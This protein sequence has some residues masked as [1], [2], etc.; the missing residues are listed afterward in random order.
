M[1]GEMRSL[2]GWW[3]RGA[4]VALCFLIGGAAQASAQID[5]AG[6]WAALS[7]QEDEVHRI[8]GPEL[9]DYAGFP[10]SEAG[11]VKAETWDASI[12]SQPELQ[13]RPHPAQY[14]MRG[15]FPNFRM[16]VVT[17][18]QTNALVALTITNLFGNADR[19][20]WMD[21]RAHPSPY[22]EHTWDGFSTGTWEGDALRVTTTH[23]KMGYIHRNG[24][25]ASPRST[26]T[27]LF[28]RHDRYLMLVTII[29]DPV[30]LEEPF[31]RTSN[32][33]WA[34][35]QTIPPP[36]PFEVVEELTNL[37]DGSV[38][39][40][41]LET[42][43]TE[44]A[45]RFNLPPAA[46]R[47]GADTMYPEYAKRMQRPSP[48]VSPLEQRIAAPRAVT[49]G[50]PIRPDV[51][52]LQVQGNVYMLVA[53]T[54]NVTAQVGD[55]GIVLVDTGD[56]QMADRIQAELRKLSSKPVRY[57]LNT[58]AGADHVGGNAPIAEAGLNLAAV[59]TAGNSGIPIVAA[60]IIAHENVLSRMSAP[61]GS[62]SPFPFAA[63][64]SSTF[65]G[66]RKTLHV[67]GEGIE[68]LH[69]P[70]AH[71][72]GDAIVYFRGSDVIST[73]D[74]FSTVSYPVIDI[75]RGGTVQ[76]VLDALAHIIDVAIPRFNLQGGTRIIPGHG[77][78]CNQAD[79]VEYRN[80]LA[81]I[82]D[83]VRRMV[84]AGMTLPQVKAARPTIDYDGLYGAST[85]D[86]TTDMFIEAVYLDA[87]KTAR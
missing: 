48:S 86:W 74:V 63:W 22:A 11:R 79:V 1:R 46:T 42:R 73:G 67:N 20:I 34:P 24:V 8:P 29:E 68:L 35:T 12:H 49:P 15:P 18:P 27:E 66:R 85:G 38:P 17:D 5:L 58:S 77:R 60:P 33:V 62:S 54:T 31:V 43:H 71:S 47:G 65:R 70:T 13:A 53:G 21:G 51:E 2:C 56:P 7:R 39:S 64:P 72:D 80:M 41:P 55:Q 40:Y 6:Q 78:I 3:R 4:L 75:A 9:G 83:R 10:L 57:V 50:L 30:Y 76:G 36:I 32:F 25:A 81:I 61:T 14:S 44:F 19:T 87:Q 59:N 37:A 69:Q 23:M 26:M 45:R 52:V 82:R 28:F 16:G 84:A